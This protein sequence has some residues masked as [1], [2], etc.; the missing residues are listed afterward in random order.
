[1]SR[2]AQLQLDSGT[3]LGRRV[4]SSQMMAELHRPEITVESDWTPVARIQHL[5]YALG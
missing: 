5:H 2:Y 3:I 1:M 4:L